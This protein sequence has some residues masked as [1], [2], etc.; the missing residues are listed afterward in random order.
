MEPPIWLIILRNLCAWPL[1]SASRVSTAGRKAAQNASLGVHC[2]KLMRPDWE[3]LA[4]PMSARFFGVR[5]SVWPPRRCQNSLSAVTGA[6]KTHQQQCCV[7][8]DRS[9]LRITVSMADE[10]RTDFQDDGDVSGLE[11]QLMVDYL[12]CRRLKRTHPGNVYLN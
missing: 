3:C 11:R 10:P 2:S 5:W 8:A 4:D 6:T 9:P 7:T 12:L 1:R